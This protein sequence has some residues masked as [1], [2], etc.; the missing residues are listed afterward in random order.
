MKII[1]MSQH[2]LQEINGEFLSEPLL[3]ERRDNLFPIIH[4]D[5]WNMY[6]NAKAS[7]WVPE[8][9]DLQFDTKD[10]NK[11][12]DNERFFIKNIL[13]F[14]AVS[15]SIISDNTSEHFSS[16]FKNV[17]EI[18]YF[19][20]FQTTIEDIH[21]H[22]YNLLIDTY[23]KNSEEKIK[24]LNVNSYSYIKAKADWCIKNLNP[25]EMSLHERILIQ[26]IYEAIF[27][28]GAFCSIFWL[29]KRGLMSGLCQANHLIS[30]DEGLHVNFG[31]LIL[32]KLIHK[33]PQLRI[34]ALVD[35]A[36]EIEIEFITKSLPI[37]LIGI[38]SNLMIQYIKF[39]SDGFL[40]KLGCKKMYNVE[41][42]F[43]W[44]E[45]ISLDSKSNFFEK[46]VSEYNKANVGVDPDKNKMS[47]DEDF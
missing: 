26:N 25:N 15:D 16:K 24:L 13:C 27:F 3:L 1:K 37:E 10:F 36:V 21:Q 7:F 39:I 30:K 31:A 4:D 42:P 14:F 23:I 12:N 19:Y 43:D 8:E 47:F 22:V 18:K 9:I 6:T 17:H 11:L 35:E 33:I 46:A 28:S 38:N 34:Y 45:M 44:I 29:K 5:I 41:N 40:I 20:N 2:R 32:N